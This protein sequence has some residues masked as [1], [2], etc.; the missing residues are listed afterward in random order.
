MKYKI[1]IQ[2]HQK[3][4]ESIDTLHLTNDVSTNDEININNIDRLTIQ[5]VS[6]S[7]IYLKPFFI[8]LD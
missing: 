4:S 8:A 3:C 1:I 5:N 6:V 7:E 2:K